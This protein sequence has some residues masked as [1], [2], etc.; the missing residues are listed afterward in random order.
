MLDLNGLIFCG[1]SHWIGHFVG[2]LCVILTASIDGKKS[3]IEKSA[4]NLH[5]NLHKKSVGG[6]IIT[7]AR[8]CSCKF[9]ASVRCTAASASPAEIWIFSVYL[10]LGGDERWRQVERWAIESN[11]CDKE[12]NESQTCTNRNGNMLWCT[13]HNQFN[14]VIVLQ[15]FHDSMK[16]TMKPDIV[17]RFNAEK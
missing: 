10:G 2:W 15:Q 17:V 1:L 6:I 7:C 12:N 9:S 11:R 16:K 5:K 8:V 3:D 13:L 4:Q 14:V